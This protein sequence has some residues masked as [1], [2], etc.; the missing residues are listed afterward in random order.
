MRRMNETLPSSALVTDLTEIVSKRQETSSSCVIPQLT[1]ANS[2]LLVAEQK[3]EFFRHHREDKRIGEL[4]YSPVYVHELPK[5]DNLR[6]SI[7]LPVVHKRKVEY[8]DG[9]IEFQSFGVP[10]YI[11]LDGDERCDFNKIYQIVSYRYSQLCKVFHPPP[12]AKD[13]NGMTA[14]NLPSNRRSVH[15]S[16][17]RPFCAPTRGRD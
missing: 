7:F 11:V 16:Y 3:E 10:F 9:H 12:E 2:Q 6:D 4:L 5:R 8:Y 14:E 1:R 15:Y 13:I 17:S